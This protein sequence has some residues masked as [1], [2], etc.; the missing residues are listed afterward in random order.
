VLNPPLGGPATLRPRADAPTIMS[1]LPALP[2][3][4]TFFELVLIIACAV[5]LAFAV[6]A[7]AVK[8]YQIPSGSM[9]PTLEVGERVIVNRLGTHFGDP[10]IGDIVVFHPPV[11]PRC[12]APHLD[13]EVC[14]TPA[15]EDTDTNFIKRVVAGP[16]DRLS[17]HNGHP[18]VNG[19]EATEDFTVPC[20]ASS[21]CDFPKPITVPE[22]HYFVMGDNRPSSDD[23]RFWGPIPKEWIIGQAIVS[24]W[25]PDRIGIF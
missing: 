24:Y 16:G 19:V 25:P 23:S 13:D 12:G 17:I 5:G 10:E 11:G 21:Q 18:V 14:P 8:P 6:Q 22:D 1:R 2:K 9:E 15:A 7:W 4:G 3:R 20:R